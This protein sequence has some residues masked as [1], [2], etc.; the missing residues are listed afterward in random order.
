MP[1]TPTTAPWRVPTRPPRVIMSTSVGRC[2]STTTI[3]RS[4]SR[5]GIPVRGTGVPPGG[6]RLTGL[7]TGTG[8]RGTPPS[9]IRGGIIRIM[10]IHITAI[11]VMAIPIPGAGVTRLM[12]RGHSGTRGPW[13]R[14]EVTQAARTV[15]D[16]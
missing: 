7:P 11:R 15:P 9:I 10:V 5:S 3:L 16:R 14:H 12:R 4:C 1:P 8:M 2:I 6:T 13:A